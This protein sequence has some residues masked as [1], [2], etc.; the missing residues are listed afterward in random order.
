MPADS[1]RALKVHQSRRKLRL[2]IGIRTSSWRLEVKG[3]NNF[4]DTMEIQSTLKV[5]LPILLLND[6]LNFN[7]LWHISQKVI[8]A[9]ESGIVVAPLISRLWKAR[10]RRQS[11]SRIFTFYWDWRHL[12]VIAG[13][14]HEIVSVN[15]I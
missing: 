6:S 11:T 3:I 5:S 13:T 4:T 12:L 7:G 14:G 15:Y 8:I 1:P 9:D 2:G 10:A